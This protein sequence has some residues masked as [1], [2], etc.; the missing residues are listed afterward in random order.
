M[1]HRLPTALAL[2]AML[3]AALPAAAETSYY[4]VTIA[5]LPAGELTLSGARDRTR[6][7]AGVSLRATGLVGALSRIRYQGWSTGE[8]AADGTIVPVRH[9]AESRSARNE[10]VTEIV[11]ENGDPARITV[12]P[13]RSRPA[14]PAAQAGTVD[15][16]SAAFALLHDPSGEALCNSRI[17]LFDG[18]RR[19][20]LE[21]GRA[22]E[23]D[24]GLVCN[25][26]YAR[27]SGDEN[28]VTDEETGIRLF[29]HPGGGEVELQRIEVETRFGLAVARRRS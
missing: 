24:G 23:R 19:S 18:N 22:Q 17:N 27:L 15:P 13:P 25:G 21:V 4:D 28:P 11:F 20:L 14:D 29:F 10:R 9:V 12:E 8:V 5:G 16:V 26:R 7:Q 3:A 1:L 2:A 6:Y